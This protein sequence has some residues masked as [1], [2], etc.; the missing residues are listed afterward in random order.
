LGTKIG[1]QVREEWDAFITYL[2]DKN[3][4]SYLEIGAREGI[5]LRYLVERLPT[6]EYVAAID[7][8][9]AAWG[10]PKSDR[11]LRENLKALGCEYK[12]F[13]GNSTDPR[14]IEAAD[15]EYDL[16]F[17]DADHSY[18][19]KWLAFHDI[20][21]LEGRPAYGATKLWRELEGDKIEFIH[22]KWNKGIGLIVA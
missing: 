8:P 17:I 12:L 3:I 21:Q 2:Q 16:V 20:N 10:R 5:A 15:R 22:P 7:L 6:I 4:K 19:G 13:L 1:G 9:N 14:V 18:A 11:E